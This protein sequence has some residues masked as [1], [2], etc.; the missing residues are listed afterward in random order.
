MGTTGNPSVG[1][2]KVRIRAGSNIYI[3]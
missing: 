1:L 2:P 3:A